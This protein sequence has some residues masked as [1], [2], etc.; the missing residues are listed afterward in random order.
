MSNVEVNTVSSVKPCIRLL[1][2]AVF[3]IPFRL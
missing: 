3:G 2:V 1:L